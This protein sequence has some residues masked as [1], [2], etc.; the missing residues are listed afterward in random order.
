M[1]TVERIEEEVQL[2]AA[3]HTLCGEIAGTAETESLIETKFHVFSEL[4]NPC[5]DIFPFSIILY[6]AIWLYSSYLIV[7]Y[8]LF[9]IHRFLGYLVTATL[10][11]AAYM[12]SS[13]SKFSLS[14]I[15]KKEYLQ[16][17]LNIYALVED[18]K[19]FPD[20]LLSI[21]LYI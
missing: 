18:S 15:I 13:S 17:Y 8:N 1:G 10:F 12:S 4:G 2:Y 19:F 6:I 7:L 20:H 21:Y 3:R 9:M 14:L 11:S 5:C 16:N